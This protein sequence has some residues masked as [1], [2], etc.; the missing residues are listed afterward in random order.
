MEIALPEIEAMRREIAELKAMVSALC[1]RLGV[2]PQAGQE[3]M[4]GIDE[5]AELA[6][7][8]AGTIRSKAKYY[9]LLATW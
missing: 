5:I 9:S 3:K 2:T 7:V 1:V 4:I 8:K 6:G